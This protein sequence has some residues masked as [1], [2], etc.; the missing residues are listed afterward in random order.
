MTTED[1]VTNVLQ[2]AQNIIDMCINGMHL[3][4][5]PNAPLKPEIMDTFPTY[6]SMLKYLGT[7]VSTIIAFMT[8]T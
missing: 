8:T 4:V 1:L 5:D 2:P 7:Q 3:M 6:E